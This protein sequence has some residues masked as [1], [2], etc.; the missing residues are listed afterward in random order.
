MWLEARS[1][2]CAGAAGGSS[3]APAVAATSANVRSGPTSQACE[4]LDHT[5][6]LHRAA[7]LLGGDHAFLAPL[8]EHGAQ[9]GRF[10][11]F[12]EQAD[13]RRADRLADFGTAIRGDQ[14]RR[15]ILPEALADV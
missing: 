12:V 7:A 5:I 4:R 14:D 9:R 6:A 10:D 8:S 13:V 1:S 15:N 2:A 11:R 3:A